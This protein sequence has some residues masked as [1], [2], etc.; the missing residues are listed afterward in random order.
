MPVQDVLSTYPEYGCTKLL[1]HGS[2]A[3]TQCVICQTTAIYVHQHH[4][5]KLKP[6]YCILWSSFLCLHG[7]VLREETTSFYF[8]IRGACL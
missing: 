2:T 6:H 3:C 5:E 8:N 7:L 4:C 1:L